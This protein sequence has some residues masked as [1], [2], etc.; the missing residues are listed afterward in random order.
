MT[1]RAY[2]R[3][4]I[5]GRVLPGALFGLALVLEADRVRRAWAAAGGL[6]P[7]AGLFAAVNSTLV[8]AYYAILVALYVVRLPPLGSDRRPGIVIASFFGTIAPM[9]IPVLPHGP[10]RDWLL[11]PSDLLSL[12]GVAWTLWALLTLGR[13]FA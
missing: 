5:L 3:D 13:S 12:L 2:W 10:R 6:Q 1:G 4:I 7:D 9:V 11:L 8:L